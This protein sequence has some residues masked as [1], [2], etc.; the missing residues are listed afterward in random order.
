M[1]NLNKQSWYSVQTN[2]NNVTKEV[3]EWVK[4]WTIK[5]IVYIKI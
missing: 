2:E 4:E 5:N 1:E 3:I